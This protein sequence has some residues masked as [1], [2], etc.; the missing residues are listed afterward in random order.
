MTNVRSRS[1]CWIPTWN[2]DH[3]GVGLE[4]LILGDRTADSI[5]L[6][7]DEEQGAFRL[8]Y[9][10]TWNE[11]WQLC[12]A[13]LAVAT[14]HSSKSL[15]LRTD[16]RGQWCDGDGRVMGD[17]NGCRDI[18]IWPTPFTN[19]FPIRRERLTVGQRKQFRMAWVSAPTL[20]V[21]PQHQAY[22]RLSDRLYLFETLD[23]SGFNVQLTVDDEGTV[24]D[25]PNFFRRV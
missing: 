21:E 6:A 13:D 24:L 23:G 4:H 12:E 14:E 22:T 25:Y 8:S 11:T 18:D 9:R 2:K 20:T 5:V 17:L 19:T 10:L 3:E 1:I 15:S 16:G 7:L